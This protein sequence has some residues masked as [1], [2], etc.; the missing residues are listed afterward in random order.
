MGGSYRSG[1][2][3]G[4]THLHHFYTK[5]NYLAISYLW[6]ECLRFPSPVRDALRLL[7]LSYNETH[8]TLMTRVVAKHG[9]KDFVLTGAQSGVLYISKLP[10]EKNV[11]KGL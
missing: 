4:I 3:Q 7:I 5:R 8:S 11:F 6:N 1:Y 9:S 10:V 2:H